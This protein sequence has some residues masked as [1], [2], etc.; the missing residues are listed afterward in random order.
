MKNLNREHVIYTMSKH[1]APVLT[2]KSGETVTVQTYDCFK[3]RLVP[4]DS[5]FDN[6]LF[7]ELNPATGPIFVE[8]ARPGDTLKVE[9]LDISLASVGVTEIDPEFGCLSHLVK[10]AVVKRLPVEGGKIHFSPRLALDIKPMIGVIGVAPAGQDIPTDTP[11]CH[12]GN[13]DCTQIKEG[14]SV[15]LPVGA[16]GGLLSLGD[17]HACMGDGEIGGCGVEIA[18][19]V[20]MKLTVISGSQKPYPVVVTDSEVMVIASSADV[21]EAWKKAVEYLHDYMIAET[22]LTS[23]EAIMLQ[24]AAADLSICQTVNPNK[25]VRM[26][27]PLKYLEAYGYSRK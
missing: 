17:L 12:G 1:H 21:E 22:E 23:D 8:G 4:D 27:V 14:A 2:V 26:S 3:D 20:T 18:G 15:Y 13:M 24:S 16:E 19:E 6:L 11:D 9:I 7:D 10:A 5:T 25:T